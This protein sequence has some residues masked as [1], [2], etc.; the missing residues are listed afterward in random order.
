MRFDLIEP[1]VSPTMNG[2]L[3]L[4]NIINIVYNIP[5]M[6]QTYKTKSTKDFNIW[7]IVLRI[8]GNTIWMVYSIEVNSLL[9]LINN[10]VT[11][12]ASLFIGYYKWREYLET[13]MGYTYNEQLLL[14]DQLLKDDPEVVYEE[15]TLY[16]PR[17]IEER[18]IL[19]IEQ[20]N[21]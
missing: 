6:V 14:D 2:F 20:D 12:I 11:V 18:A 16:T 7:F 17:P 21:V 8:I 15:Q 1:K 13:Q 19:V 9:M 5:Q 4:A 3:I 10:S